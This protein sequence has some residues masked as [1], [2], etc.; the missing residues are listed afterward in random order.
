MRYMTLVLGNV[1]AAVC[2][3]WHEFTRVA[4][5]ESFPTMTV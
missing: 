4:G 2:A 5:K 1:D 3:L